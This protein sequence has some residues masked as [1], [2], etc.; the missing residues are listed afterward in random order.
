MSVAVV[1][2]A[3]LGSTRLPRKALADIAGE[4]MVV[5]VWRRAKQA[6]GIAQVVVATDSEEIAAV[7]RAAGGEALLTRADH[8]S[9]TDRVAEV[10][11]Q[12]DHGSIVNVQGDLP[13]LDSTY[14]EVLAQALQTSGAPMAT[15]ATPL[16][17]EEAGRAQVVKVVRN[18]AGDALY[19]SRSP[20]PYGGGPGLRHIGM[21]AYQREF[22]LK[23]A[24]LGPTPL[25][26]AEKLEQLRVLEHGFRL[27]VALVEAD[28]D[29]V[30][31]DTLED[32]ERARGVL[33]RRG[34]G[35]K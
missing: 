6:H 8:P 25:E 16:A 34:A 5:H 9:G 27:Q 13:L 29:M 23:L 3:R 30:E 20:L 22:L 2:P 1:I 4:P 15:L 35:A 24:A 7:V 21:Y 18:L 33:A 32:L 14:I 11:R 31:V 10:A 26:Q 19:F 17:P 28:G 12:L